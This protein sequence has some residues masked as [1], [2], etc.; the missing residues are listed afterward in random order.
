M[1][2]IKTTKELKTLKNKKFQ[3]SPSN[4]LQFNFFLNIVEIDGILSRTG[5]SARN[6]A[7]FSEDSE[8]TGLFP[9]RNKLGFN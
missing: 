1:K 5:D 9:V 4:V 2:S 8:H 3:S 6:S 7:Q